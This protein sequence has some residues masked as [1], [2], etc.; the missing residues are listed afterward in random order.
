VIAAL[1]PVRLAP[2]ALGVLLVAA[3]SAANEESDRH[4]A[5]IAAALEGYLPKLGQAYATGDVE[6]L[7]G[8]TDEREL[9]ALEKKIVDRAAEGTVLEPKFESVAIES[10]QVWNDANAAAVTLE[11]WDLDLYD[12]ETREI[13][14]QRLNQRYRIKYELRREGA[15]WMVTRRSIEKV[16]E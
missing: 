4:R 9:A 13:A 6:V 1:G 11:Q 5:A 8:L 16:F 7:R 10:L 2:V 3:C 14:N 12:L 15:T